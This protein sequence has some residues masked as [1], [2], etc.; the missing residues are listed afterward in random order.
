VFS[1]FPGNYAWSTSVNLA[2]MAGGTIGDIHRWLAPLRDSGSTDVYE[3]GAA[4]SAMGH[5]QE[6]LAEIDVRAG[7]LTTAG[8]RLLRASVYHASGQRQIP[9]GPVKSESYAAMLQAFADAVEHTPLPVERIHVDSPDGTLPGYLIPATSRLDA[10]GRAPVVIVFGGLDMTKELL[11]AII[12]RTF[13]ERG[14]TCL[15]IDTPGVGEPLR[16]RG[17]PARPDSE[18]PAAAII[19][20]L[21]TREGVDASRIAVMGLSLG[22]YYAA[23]AAAFE[24]RIT[25]CVAWAGI[26]D[27]GTTWRRRWETGAAYHVPWFQLPWAL[28]EQTMEG[29]L[30]RVAQY[31]LVDVWQHVTQPLLIVHGEDDQQIPLADAARAFESAGATDKELRVFTASDG[32]AEHIQTDDP[33]PARQLIADWLAQRLVVAPRPRARAFGIAGR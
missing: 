10:G 1:Y 32:G 2:L 28:G 11:Y 17:V 20:D 9:P 23:R 30:E 7:H 19:D 18:V 15:V 4:W 24:K 22:G 25:A 13:A 12:G 14:I 29:A 8:T 31:S 16:I 6:A 5:Q 21:E 26:W 3:W 27:W 33:D